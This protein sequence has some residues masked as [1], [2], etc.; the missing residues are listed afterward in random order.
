MTVSQALPLKPLPKIFC[1]S[2]LA[3]TRVEK[4]ADP[5]EQG[6]DHE[7]AE[8]K[9]GRQLDQGF[10]RDR[11]HQSV[12]MLGRIDMAGAEQDGERC[13]SQRNDEGGIDTRQRRGFQAAQ[14]AG[15]R[16]APRPRCE[17][18]LSCRAM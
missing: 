12:L 1:S 16:V 4:A 13:Q 11:Q 2:A 15:H 8:R 3:L 9:E 5:A 6:H 18:A 17:M 7:Y 14:Q 10:G